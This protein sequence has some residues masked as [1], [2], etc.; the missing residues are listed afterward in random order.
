[1]GQN[2]V[3]THKVHGTDKVSHFTETETGAYG[4]KVTGPSL[5]QSANW[6]P[7]WKPHLPAAPD[8]LLCSAA[9]PCAVDPHLQ[10]RFC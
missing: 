3:G 5:C 8:A 7:S 2:K 4:E 9:A 10:L 6:G 1:M